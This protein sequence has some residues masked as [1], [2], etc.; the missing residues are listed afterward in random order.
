MHDVEPGTIDPD[1]PGAPAASAERVPAESATA[2]PAAAELD[3]VNQIF[4]HRLQQADLDQILTVL[5]R[6]DRDTLV[7][8]IGDILRRVAS[9]LG[10]YNRIADALDLDVLLLRLIEII[11]EALDADRSTLFLHDEETAELFSRVAQG[12]Q[13]NE[14]RFP[15]DRG[16][17]GSVFTTGK[18]IIIDDA[19]ADPRFNPE[20]DRR[21]G[22]LTRNILCVPL[23]NRE[24]RI[25]GATQVL[26][27]HSAP[28]DNEDRQMLE[29]ITLHASG[30][31]EN[32]KL[33]ES[34]ERQRREEEKMIE[35]ANAIST[36]LQLEPLLA[37]IM[38]AITELLDADRSTL[39][40]Y[41]RKNDQLWSRVAEG[42]GGN[43]KEIRFP[44][45]RDIAGSVFKSRKILN[46]PDAYADTRFNPEV[47]RRTG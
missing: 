34:V 15:S 21:T 4:E 8:K 2:E 41:D 19:Y 3:I 20:V 40:M 9:L 44:A 28:F 38:S 11:T 14:I 31:L 5:N 33:H 42:L 39:F 24:G 35:V 22:Y 46:I 43:T 26:N 37:K 6:S 36:E 25:I 30:A 1:G 23:K 17:A 18:P 13:T 47:D 10:V 32:A 16:I 45:D 29:A 27:K 12:S 7:N